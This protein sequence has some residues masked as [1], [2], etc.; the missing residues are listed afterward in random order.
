MEEVWSQETE[1]VMRELGWFP[2][3][4]VDTTRWREHFTSV[5]LPPTEAAERFLGEYGGLVRE[6]YLMVN[7]PARYGRGSAGLEALVLGI[8]PETLVP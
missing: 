5:G 3:R 8:M 7:W 2:G 4:R 6:H 1:Q